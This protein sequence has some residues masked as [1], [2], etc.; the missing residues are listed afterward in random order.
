MRWAARGCIRQTVA[1][2]QLGVCD[3]TDQFQYHFENVS[4]LSA[5]LSLGEVIP[6]EY[7]W[8][9][10]TS[11]TPWTVN[12]RR[13]D[14]EP[15]C[16]IYYG[17]NLVGIEKTM[18]ASTLV[19]RLY[20][21]GYGEGVNQLTIREANNG[22][23]YIDADTVSVWGV[24][25]S[26]YTDTRILDAATLKARA[27][28]VLEGYKNPYI[29]YTA[30]AV[31]L[32]RLTGYS[33]DDF[34]PGKLVT[35]MD[36]EHGISFA[37]RIVSISKSDVNGDPGAIQITIANAPRDTADSINTLADR[38]GIGELYSQ[39]AT[40]LFSIPFA[41]NADASHPAKMRVYVP[42]GLVRINKMVLSWQLSAFRAYETGAA[43][44]AQ[45]TET[46]SSTES[47][48]STSS[49]G[50]GS[51]VTS[52]STTSEY[53]TS[54][55]GG[56]STVTSAS[57]GSSTS[58]S[59]AGGGAT[60][61]TP[62]TTIEGDGSSS[63]PV[64]LAADIPKSSSTG[65]D[66]RTTGLAN[67][68]VASGGS[69]SHGMDHYHTASAHVHTIDA[70]SHTGPSHT[71]GMA[72]NH[73]LSTHAHGSSALSASTNSLHLHN[74]PG[75]SSSVTQYSGSLTAAVSIS[76]STDGSGTL[77]TSS[78]K[79][80]GGSQM[81]NTGSA[82]DGDTSSVNLLANSA[83]ALAT[84][85]PLSSG[86]AARTS[87]DSGGSH[88]HTTTDHNHDMNH[89]HLVKGRI[90]I[91]PMDITVPEHSHSVT[92][93]AHTHD[94][95]TSDHT[96]SVEIPGHNHSVTISDHTHTV[97]IPG[98]SHTVT[99][100]G[101]SHGIV[102]GIYEGGTATSVSIVVDGTTVPAVEI[103]GAE[104]DVVPYLQTDTD[105]KITRGAWHEIRI[106]PDQL[107]RI[108][109]NLAAQVFVQ[110]V[111]GGDY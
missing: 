55:S 77:T 90:T 20:P 102:Y 109:A 3:F 21:L 10:D 17:R 58:T 63:L 50:G 94:V 71:H 45:S 68:T 62:Q 44:S 95:T 19:T 27:E 34:M 6:E 38:V 37:A 83:G 73:T 59:A 87:T 29:T 72:H 111:G 33:W 49:S 48:Q 92:V 69:H 18:D 85:G 30:N 89:T 42:S 28:Q 13:A 35:V 79:D 5:L 41:D 56:G 47:T 84:T 106:V 23:P 36:G 8:D 57:G 100:P 51:T 24:K 86:G 67:V 4:L 52:G 40:N 70:H 9:F 53:K 14:E 32:Y 54:S 12:L 15:G 76:G 66:M 81:S 11:T 97:T 1:R 25:C 61:A 108:E 16:G 7:T 88:S 107:T 74:Y 110:S 98:H 39:G 60:V 65:T 43:S 78:S 64:V 2:W 105:G 99:I 104:L 93:P 22:L 103:T 46:T 80:S 96:H 101:H 31:D 26:V 75:T 82:G 91:P